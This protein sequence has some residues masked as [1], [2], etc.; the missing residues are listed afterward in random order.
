MSMYHGEPNRSEPESWECTHYSVGIP[1][2]PPIE[3]EIESFEAARRTYE[4]AKRR[5][6]FDEN[7][8]GHRYV[9]YAH[10]RYVGDLAPYKG[11]TDKRIV[12]Q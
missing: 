4:S 1:G 12:M 3:E 6:S 7:L 9:I 10:R 5:A 8:M 2:E 11:K